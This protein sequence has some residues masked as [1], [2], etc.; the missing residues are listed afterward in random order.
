MATS[1]HERRYR[2]PGSAEQL[3]CAIELRSR[4]WNAEGTA[5]G[6]TKRLPPEGVRRPW[7]CD[8]RRGT[9]SLGSAEDAADVAGILH[10]VRDDNERVRS[11]EHALKGLNRAAR[12]ADNA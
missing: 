3:Q 2:N 5:H 10:V 6:T 12:D 11:A 8:E 9:R 4:N 7:R 1:R